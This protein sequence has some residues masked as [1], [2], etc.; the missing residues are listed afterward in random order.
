MEVVGVEAVLE[1]L[2]RLDRVDAV[3]AVKLRQAR[4]EHPVLNRRQNLVADILVERHA[5]LEGAE[6]VHHPAAEDS[7]GTAGPE[8]L[9]QAGQLLRS[10][11]P[12]A[13]HHRDEV[14]LI[15]D[16]VR[17]ADLLVAAVALVVLVA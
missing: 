17:V 3:A 4:P 11:L 9:E 15:R 12:V 13:V 14:E 7:V 2:E 10:V 16:R 5:P 1:T 8:R 6:P